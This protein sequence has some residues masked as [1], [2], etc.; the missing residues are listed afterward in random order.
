MYAENVKFRVNDFKK[1]SSRV[2][3]A[4]TSVAVRIG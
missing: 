4:D 2:G 3:A 1:D